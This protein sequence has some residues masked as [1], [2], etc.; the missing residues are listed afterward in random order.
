MDVC[1]KKRRGIFRLPSPPPP[2]PHLPITTF[3]GVHKKI[4]F[5]IHANVIDHKRETGGKIYAPVHYKSYWKLLFPSVDI[6]FKLMRYFPLR[7]MY[8]KKLLINSIYTNR[9]KNT[10]K[11]LI[12]SV[13]IAFS[14]N[15]EYLRR[16]MRL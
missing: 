2:P 10:N 8:Y 7:A 9:I 15:V 13:R 6:N 5:P 16:I 4:Y 14:L 3:C 1:F 11:I 12:N